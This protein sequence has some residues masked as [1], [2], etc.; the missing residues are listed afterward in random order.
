M[1]RVVKGRNATVDLLQIVGNG[2]CPML[3][4]RGCV[5]QN[6]DQAGRAFTFLV[7]IGLARGKER[8][9]SPLPLAAAESWKTRT[10]PERYSM[11]D[12]VSG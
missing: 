12:G 11:A 1:L 7:R 5:Q 2:R 10:R 3:S 4:N 8:P 6:P 9:R